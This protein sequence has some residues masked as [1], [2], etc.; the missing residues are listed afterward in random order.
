MKA[1]LEL[2]GRGIGGSGVALVS[3]GMAAGGGATGS[4]YTS[5]GGGYEQVGQL[6][7]LYKNKS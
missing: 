3:R 7:D 2:E 4:V 5:S 6:K 1:G